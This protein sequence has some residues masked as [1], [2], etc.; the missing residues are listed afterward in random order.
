LDISKYDCV[1]LKGVYCDGYSWLSASLWSILKSWGPGMWYMPLIPELRRQM[2]ADLWFWSQ[3][4]QKVLGQPSLWN[5]GCNK[6]RR[7]ACFS[8]N[9][10]HK[11]EAL[12]ILLRFRVKSRRRLLGHLM[13]VSHS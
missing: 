11:L 3:F 12:A 8:P 13:L 5:Q 9:K 4:T 7:E 6:T 10:Q 2:H 1:K